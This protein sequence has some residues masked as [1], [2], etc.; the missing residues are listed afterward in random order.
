MARKQAPSSDPRKSEVAYVETGRE[1]KGVRLD[2]SPSDH[3]RLEQCAKE[4]GLSM[5]SY[6]RQAVLACIRGDERENG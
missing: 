5:A 3:I 2:L 6:A 4:R 1:V